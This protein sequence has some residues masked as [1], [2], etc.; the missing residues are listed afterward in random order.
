MLSDTISVGAPP[1][2]C[3]DSPPPYHVALT[4][5]P[6][7]QGFTN[8]AFQPDTQLPAN[9]NHQTPQIFTV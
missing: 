4:M 6:N 1:A 9:K 2:Y 8:R 3:E 7:S 5:Y